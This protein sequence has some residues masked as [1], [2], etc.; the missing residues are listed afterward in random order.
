MSKGGKDLRRRHFHGFTLIELLVTVVVIAIAASIAIPVFSVW[1][2][3]YRVQAAARDLFSNMQ[4]AKLT[5]IRQNQDCSITFS[6][7][8]DQYTISLLNKTVTLADY[9]SGVKF[10][11]PTH[12][13]TFETN[14]LT[15]N[16]RGLSNSGYVYLSNESGSVY[17]RVSPL[18]SGA[19]RLQKW[20]GIHFE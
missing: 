2:P 9:K 15:F 13:K 10:D 19:I 4:L 7:D 20:N 12:S 1:L 8:P 5:A 11:D 14:P 18:T 17:Y 6:T 16:N 3:N